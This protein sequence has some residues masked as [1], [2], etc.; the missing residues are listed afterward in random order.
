MSKYRVMFN[1][2]CKE[3]LNSDYGKVFNIYIQKR[4]FGFWFTVREDFTTGYRLFDC[5]EEAFT[6]VESIGGTVE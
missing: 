6:Y 1:F 4:V 2:G 5:A 3:S